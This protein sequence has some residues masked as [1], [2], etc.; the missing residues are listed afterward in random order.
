MVQCINCLT[1]VRQFEVPKFWH[2]DEEQSLWDP[3]DKMYSK[4]K[5]SWVNDEFYIESLSR[6]YKTCTKGL[7]GTL[8]MEQEHLGWLRMKRRT[9]TNVSISKRVQDLV[10]SFIHY[11][12]AHL[13]TML[14]RYAILPKW[15]INNMNTL[16][17]E[18]FSMDNFCNASHSNATIRIQY[19]LPVLR[20]RCQNVVGAMQ[21]TKKHSMSRRILKRVNNV[22]H[23]MMSGNLEINQKTI[24]Q[25]AKDCRLGGHTDVI[26]H[27]LL[28]SGCIVK[29]FTK[30]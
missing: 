10:L 15:F 14:K 13:Q 17:S 21:W 18:L 20:S 19:E 5:A 27:K 29:Q 8:Q 2:S 16:K 28:E 3:K 26:V 24:E 12:F 30:I 11:Q 22:V 6:A 23:S 25:A 9:E 1:F 7:Y 4:L